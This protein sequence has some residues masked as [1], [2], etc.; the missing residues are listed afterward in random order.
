MTTVEISFLNAHH[1]TGPLRWL[2]HLM[3]RL[4]GGK[5]MRRVL[6]FTFLVLGFLVLESYQDMRHHEFKPQTDEKVPKGAG[7]VL[8]QKSGRFRSQ[9]NFYLTL[10]TFALFLII[11]RLRGVH[12]EFDEVEAELT[13]K[14]D[15]AKAKKD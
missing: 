12:A 2:Q 13:T 6:I 4:L 3:S 5:Q 9:R 15:R 7:S 8:L 10:F 14:A 1:W 11:M